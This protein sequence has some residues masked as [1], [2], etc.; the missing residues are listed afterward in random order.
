MVKDETDFYVD[1][2]SGSSGVTGSCNICSV[3]F[4]DGK[5]QKFVIDFG[6]YQEWEY[7][8]FNRELLIDPDSVSFVIATHV[9]LDHVGR[10]PMLIRN[11][12][13]GKIF[14]TYGTQEL[15][16]PALRDA[17]AIMRQKFSRA[18]TKYRKSKKP[19][20]FQKK[21][22]G[23]KDR[24]G[25]G[26]N[27]KTYK[28]G[29]GKNG[30]NYLKNL[31]P[32]YDEYN[33]ADTLAST[34]GVPYEKWQKFNKNISFMF[35]KNAHLPGAACVLVKISYPGRKSITILFTGDWNK[36]NLFLGEI[37]L[38]NKVKNLKH[39]HVV[40]EAT[41]GTT[42][43]SEVEPCFK[44][45]ILKT[46]KK[47]GSV[48]VPAFSLGRAQ[49][50]LYHLKQMQNESQLSTAI[51]IYYGGKLTAT[52]T[53]KFQVAG[54]LEVLTEMRDFLPQ[55]LTFVGKK[56]IGDVL[57]KE[58][59]AIFVVSS[60]MC[61]F[62]LSPICAKHFLGNSNALIHFTGYCAEGTWG[63]NLIE[64]PDGAKVKF[65]GYGDALKK[66]E[67]VSTKEFS[68]HAKADELLEYCKGFKGMSTLLLTHGSPDVKENFKEFLEPGGV[69]AE[70]VCLDRS[71]YYRLDD[72]GIV[73]RKS[74]KF[75]PIP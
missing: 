37:D 15:L 44:D 14:C 59:Q 25:H 5:R 3:R 34:E 2:M 11:G 7:E 39:L 33:V 55:N 38:P 27:Y 69:E 24:N 53:K 22:S 65:N 21:S 12:Y 45:N 73:F 30:D 46:L 57:G 72:E 35:L 4:P 29:N 71:N 26:K 13:E 10:L 51:P 31:R 32:L 23:K 66:A 61:S 40:M 58:E 17:H 60:G 20:S 9:H 18:L 68:T 50:V 54:S 41:Y 1:L 64:A 47:G 56:N 52:Y 74:T 49:E 75:K 28:N 70:V 43:S 6:Q 62:G 42:V 36:K 8:G 16:E 48:V 19:E 63:R 67:V